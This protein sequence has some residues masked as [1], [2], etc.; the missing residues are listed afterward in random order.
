MFAG[1]A[2]GIYVVTVDT[3]FYTVIIVMCPGGTIDCVIRVRTGI[4]TINLMNLC[5]AYFTAI[6][7]NAQFN[8][9]RIVLFRIAY[10][11]FLGTYT[12]ANTVLVMSTGSMTFFRIVRM[13]TRL[14]AVVKML[15]CRA[16]ALGGGVLAGLGAAVLMTGIRTLQRAL[17][18]AGAGLGH[19]AQK[20]QP[21]DPTV[22]I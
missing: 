19:L 9:I 4:D 3:T 20:H 8:T 22:G 1:G 12:T 21:E 18:V 11:L 5:G 13:G 6:G 16:H 14:N 2:Y 15:T 17:V 10:A 7:F